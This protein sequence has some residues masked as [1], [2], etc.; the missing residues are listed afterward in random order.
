MNEE[1]TYKFSFGEDIRFDREQV[2]NGTPVHHSRTDHENLQLP[3]D[4]YIDDEV[5]LY[6][7]TF[8]IGIAYRDQEDARSNSSICACKFIDYFCSYPFIITTCIL[9]S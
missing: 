6:N 4:K 8:S 7:M 9:F 2:Y 3:E 1:F 5:S